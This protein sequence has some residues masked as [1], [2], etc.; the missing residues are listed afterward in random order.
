MPSSAT[1]VSEVLATLS[2]DEKTLQFFSLM[3]QSAFVPINSDVTTGGSVSLE[4]LSN[5]FSNMLSQIDPNLDLNVNYRIATDNS[6]SNEFEFGFSRQFWNDRI[7]VNVNG[8][9]DFGAS[10]STP[11][12]AEQTQTSDFSGTVSVE[13]KV[14]KRGTIKVKG[15]SR[16][17]EDEL[18]EKQ[19]NTNG[20]GFFFTKDFN[21]LKDLFRK[22]EEN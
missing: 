14:N 21:T 6:M 12:N 20:V 19:E 7:L 11:T 15:F 1:H 13:M 18:T 16:S 3:L 9:T 22:Q 17:N 8:Y 4:V 5:Q 2:E 10:E